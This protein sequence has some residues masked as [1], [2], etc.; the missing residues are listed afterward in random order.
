MRVFETI[1]NNSR[2]MYLNRGFRLVVLLGLVCRGASLQCKSLCVF[3]DIPTNASRTWDGC[4]AKDYTDGDRQCTVS[5]RV[6]HKG[7]VSSGQIAVGKCTDG[8][9]LRTETIITFD[10]R[11]LHINSYSCRIDN[12]DTA[13]LERQF[14]Y[15]ENKWSSNT[16]DKI[17][18]VVDGLYNST[19]DSDQ[20]PCCDKTCLSDQLCVN[21]YVIAGNSSSNAESSQCIDRAKANYLLNIRRDYDFEGNYTTEI[22]ILSNLNITLAPENATEIYEQLEM[23]NPEFDLGTL[24]ISNRTC[25]SPTSTGFQP[26][27]SVSTLLIS[28]V[29]YLLLDCSLTFSTS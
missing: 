5:M 24:N 16:A 23:L 11:L 8:P 13:F 6:D 14:P 22:T 27:V 7:N 29:T 1:D 12:C 15:D 9:V 4:T 25:N 19:T 26:V 3:L 28:F 17:G 18:T 20:F 10:R 2:G 21:K